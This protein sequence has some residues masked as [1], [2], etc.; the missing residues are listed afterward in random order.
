MHCNVYMVYILHVISFEK[1]A[2]KTGVIQSGPDTAVI[3]RSSRGS[4][5]GR[6]DAPG[7]VEKKR[8]MLFVSSSLFNA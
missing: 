5:V 3:V 1:A 2:W 6:R 7:F 8:C 4:S